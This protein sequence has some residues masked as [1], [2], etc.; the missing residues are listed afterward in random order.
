[1]MRNGYPCYKFKLL[2]RGIRRHSAAKSQR[3]RRPLTKSKLRD[4]IEATYELPIPIVERIRL[5][6]CILLAF[7]GFFRSASYCQGRA[8][9]V[10]RHS[11]IKFRKLASG[12]CYMVASLRK[13]K[14]V[15]FNRTPVFIYGT[16]TAA[17]C[18]V[19]AVR[20]FLNISKRLGM[21]KPSSQVFELQGKPLRY[22]YFNSLLKDCAQIAGLDPKL[23]SSHS[24]RSGAATSA[25]SS[26]IPP[27]LIQKLG[28]WSSN[29]Y[30][31]YIKQ[32][33]KAIRDAQ[34]A[35]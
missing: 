1:M 25:A 23:Y 4:I 34:A 15:Q 14:T 17:I 26:G 30:C 3:V 2:M 12:K 31:S 20:S 9:S 10:L 22:S 13:S 28:R 33:H 21:V 8:K 29:A 24:L 5:R 19:K 27:Y 32:P 35:M 11:D 7:W 16:N 6:A 18:P